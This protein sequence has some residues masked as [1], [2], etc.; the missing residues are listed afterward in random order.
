MLSGSA[1]KRE[2]CGWRVWEAT[3]CREVFIEE[4]VPCAGVTAELC[5]AVAEECLWDQD[6]GLQRVGARDVPIPSAGPSE[7]MVL[8]SVADVVNAVHAVMG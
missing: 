6:G 1:V 3:S 5:A 8:P 2:S 7:R 4:G